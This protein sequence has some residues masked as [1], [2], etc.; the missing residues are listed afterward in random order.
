MRLK[1]FSHILLSFIISL[2][3]IGG[4]ETYGAVKKTNQ[5]Q[6]LQLKRGPRV[7][8]KQLPKSQYQ[9]EKRRRNEKKARKKE[10]AIL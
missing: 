2:A 6:Q 7:K 9:K 5:R 8:R 3:C 1:I 4:I 10:Q